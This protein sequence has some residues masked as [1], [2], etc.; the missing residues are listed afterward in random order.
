MSD[1]QRGLTELFHDF[2]RRA[3]P[4]REP[5]NRAISKFQTLSDTVQLSSDTVTATVQ[6][7][8]YQYAAQSYRSA[9]IA[10]APTAYWRLGEMAPA[11]TA[12]DA[13]SSSHGTYNGA[14]LLGYPGPMV[15]E[16][17][18]CAYL[19]GSTAVFVEVATGGYQPL[20]SGTIELWVYPTL[21][22]GGVYRTIIAKNSAAATEGW[23]VA[24]NS[25]TLLRFT[26]RAPLTDITA[27]TTLGQFIANTW[28]HV[29]VKFN[30]NDVN[31]YLNN[32]LVAGPTTR[33][34]TLASTG[35]LVIGL[36]E[37]GSPMTG[38]V[39]EVALYT[40]A[41]TTTRIAAHYQVATAP[42]STGTKLVVGAGQFR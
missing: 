3:R 9:V 4:G 41:L 8:P 24:I 23:E 19:S 36:R 1:I 11:V 30:A 10:D 39:D 22:G 5:R 37:S 42:V 28:H 26:A 32:A 16:P 20:T 25:D 40:S 12:Q 21:V 17:D 7:P 31:L 2:D 13:S 35:R 6:T 38:F 34:A 14:V 27:A 15:S 18:P 29:V 33:T